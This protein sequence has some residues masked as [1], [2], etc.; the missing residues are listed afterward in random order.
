MRCRD[1]NAAATTSQFDR[2]HRDGK[3]PWSM[4][5]PDGVIDLPIDILGV[6]YQYNRNCQ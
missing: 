4:T 6:I 5:A 2:G 3:T 1:S